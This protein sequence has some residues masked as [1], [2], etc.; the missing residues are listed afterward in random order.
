[1]ASEFRAAESDEWSVCPDAAALAAALDGRGRREAA[2][3]RALEAGCGTKISSAFDARLGAR[4]GAK[5]VDAKSAAPKKAG[6]G[7]GAAAPRATKL[8]SASDARL[9]ARKGA[10]LGNSKSA[11]APKE[12]GGKSRMAVDVSGTDAATVVAV[13]ASTAGGLQPVAA[14]ETGSKES[15]EKAIRAS[16]RSVT[17]APKARKKRA[18]PEGAIANTAI[19][20]GAREAAQHRP[21]KAAVAS[22]IER[23]NEQQE[24]Q[25][26]AEVQQSSSGIQPENAPS[27]GELADLATLWDGVPAAVPPSMPGRAKR[28]RKQ[29]FE[30]LCF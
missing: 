16:V 10:N 5:I 7:A 13:A 2:L 21:S 12:A 1:M 30:S 23:H 8:S 6:C 24:R 17:A 27:G 4:E 19:A 11:A 22:A 26:L 25:A 15:T 14:G 9:G 28:H 20:D 29:K 18:A 3:L